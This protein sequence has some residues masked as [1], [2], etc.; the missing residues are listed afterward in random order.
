MPH[1]LLIGDANSAL[2]SHLILLV[3]DFVQEQR[4]DLRGEA[5]MRVC[6]PAL[7]AVA[8]PEGLRDL[9]PLLLLVQF[10]DRLRDRTEY[11]VEAGGGENEEEGEGH[12]DDVFAAIHLCEEESLLILKEKVEG[13]P[14]AQDQGDTGGVILDHREFHD[15]EM[16]Q[17]GC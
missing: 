4:V 2:G 1:S 16:S 13:D 15:E 12:L 11:Q 5:C 9:L 6:H 17:N 14:D 10:L 7:E 3:T 8:L